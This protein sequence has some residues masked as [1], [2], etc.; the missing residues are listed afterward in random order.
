MQLK[1]HFI[2]HCHKEANIQEHA[3]QEH[4]DNNVIIT[5][6]GSSSTS[7]PGGTKNVGASSGFITESVQGPGGALGYFLGGYVPPGTP[8]W[9]PVLKKISPKIN[10][11]F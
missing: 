4:Y 5:T 10:T 8:N 2:T 9:Y 6:G 1:F 3:S 11:P 7:F